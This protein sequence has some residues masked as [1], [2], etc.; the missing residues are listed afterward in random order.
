MKNFRTIV[1][2]SLIFVIALTL[3]AGNFLTSPSPALANQGNPNLVRTF[4]GSD[5]KQIDELIF[6]AKPP[7]T[8]I[9]S[10]KVPE[11]NIQA[12]INT[13]SQ[14]SVPAFDWSYGCSSTSAAMLF[15]YYDL[16]GYSSMYTGPTNGGKCPL[17][18]SVWGHTAYP[19]VTCGECPLSATHLGVDVRTMRGHVDD[20]WIDYGNKSSDPYIVGK[21]RQ[22]AGDSVG[23]FM[24]TNQSAW[25]NSD[26]ATTFYFY[27][28]GAAYSGTGSPY[29]D[30]GYGMRLFA[31]SKGYTVT[32]EFNQYILGYN[33]NTLG[34]TFA[35]YMTEIDAGRPVLI[36]VSGHTMLGFG[37][38][39]TDITVYLHDTWDYSDH[40]MT[41]GGS[42]SGM[43]HYG[44]TVF[45]L[46]TAPVPVAP[47]A[48]FGGS[49]VSGS[50]PLTVNFTDQSAYS[51]TSW[52]WTFGDGAS[53]S[54]QNPSHTYTTAGIYSVALMVTN[55]AGNDSTNRT[56]YITVSTPAT[57]D[58][59]ISAS[60]SSRTVN[61]GSSTSYTVSVTARGGF[62]SPVSLSVSGLPGGASA[63]FS[64]SS[65][66]SGT[67]TLKVRTTRTTSRGT[68]S[69]TITGISGSLT[70]KT[71]VL[72]VIR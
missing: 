50:A 64:P 8:K 13:V 62:S 38:D 40:Q 6:P 69:L 20:Y 18:N 42:Y 3:I 17:D 71:T 49:P 19:S 59:S 14:S 12:G 57:R 56:N 66:S 46:A 35:N 28:N 67:S 55:S 33:G 32:S 16:V 52:S 11:P 72:L 23:D 54:A 9:K 61:R 27:T 2:I 60:P 5:G 34:F 48:A 45:R 70:H 4:I 22:H 29:R 10:V 63:S 7:D 43:Q 51:P 44:V 26:G 25:N 30:G 37:Y 36:Q 41:W 65:L 24:G 15:G 68:Y 21:W 31:E 58:F 53:S 47:V 1:S 39:T